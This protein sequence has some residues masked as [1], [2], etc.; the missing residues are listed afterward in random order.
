[1]DNIIKQGYLKKAKAT[2]ANRSSVASHFLQM[3]EP[4]RW[5][6]LGLRS[7][8]PY[9]E[10]YDKEE[11]VFSEQPINTYDLGLCQRLTYTLGRTNKN[12]TFCLFLQ[13]RVIE[14]TAE[15]R[16]AMLDWCRVLE[17]ALL[18]YGCLKKYDSNH[19][20]SE[21][22]IKHVPTKSEEVEDNPDVNSIP[23]LS[24]QVDENGGDEAAGSSETIPV[25]SPSIQQEEIIFGTQFSLMEAMNQDSSETTEESDLPV[26]SGI[27][28]VVYRQKSSL[29]PDELDTSEDDFVTKDFWLNNKL[30][31]VPKRNKAPPLPERTLSLFV[32]GAIGGINTQE[33][34]SL[35]D[36]LL[37]SNTLKNERDRK[38]HSA[39]VMPSSF[40]KSIPPIPPRNN[41]R[42]NSNKGDSSFQETEKDIGGACGSSLV[43]TTDNKITSVEDLDDGYQSILECTGRPPLQGPKFFKSSSVECKKSIDEDRKGE[44]T[45]YANAPSQQQ[46]ATNTEQQKKILVKSRMN[47]YVN[48]PVQEEQSVTTNSSQSK[49]VAENLYSPFPGSLD[50]NTSV[51]NNNSV[52]T[53][54]TL[55][56][57]CEDCSVTKVKMSHVSDV[58]KHV[59]D[60]KKHVS[61]VKNH[62][63]DVKKQSGI[64]TLGTTIPKLPSPEDITCPPRKNVNPTSDATPTPPSLDSLPSRKISPDHTKKSFPPLPQPPPPSLDTL[65]KKGLNNSVSN[66]YSEPLKRSPS[67]PQRSPVQP[68]R[69]PFDPQRSPV[70]PTRNISTS[71]SNKSSYK[72]NASIDDVTNR[73][74]PSIPTEKGNKSPTIVITN[75]R[76][77]PSFDDFKFETK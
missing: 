23:T 71:N 70:P 42:N 53:S 14:L 68:T 4:Q 45:D 58:K 44:V 35:N 47:D 18:N 66:D 33:G 32:P 65:P 29:K 12:W 26:A 6:V 8:R 22:P 48:T 28:G 60:V 19:V 10:Y 27:D 76:T 55:I 15:S 41:E 7:R 61:D 25:N 13:D 54:D 77:S 38:S 16:S 62:V 34:T 9:L 20:Y 37:M 40:L 17:R 43:T 5:Y 67:D 3:L 50:D 57:D 21:F 11:H 30:P 59:S 52:N 63:S 69:F 46:N 72:S 51:Q 2:P 74:L 1:M 64:S 75:G 24:L 49:V 73:P 36:Q 56:N 31:P 39:P